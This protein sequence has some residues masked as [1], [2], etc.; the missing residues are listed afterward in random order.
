MSYLIYFLHESRALLRSLKRRV[1][2]YGW[3]AK[4]RKLGRY[5]AW[6]TEFSGVAPWLDD[7]RFSGSC[8]FEKQLTLWSSPDPKAD[9]QL[10]IGKNVYFGRNTYLGLHA[11]IQIGDHV[12]IG[13]YSY[14]IS[15]NHG[16]ADRQIPIYEQGY[17]AA[18]III[19]DLVWIGA[20]VMVLP[21]VR[22]GKGAIIG[23]HS[24]V[25]K[26]IESWSI[27]AGNPCRVIA[28]RPTP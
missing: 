18:P 7:I 8:L 2:E 15:C 10:T 23:A 21:G 26:D 3:V 22:I 17:E 1:K 13:A 19:E 4:Q 25:T 9:R 27:A 6:D 12:Q 24:V 11:L 16:Y 28:Q 14:L 5:F 20:H